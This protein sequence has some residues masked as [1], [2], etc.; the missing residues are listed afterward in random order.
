MHSSSSS[1]IAVAAAWRLRPQARRAKVLAGG[2][3][4]PWLKTLQTPVMPRVSFNLVAT[5]LQRRAGC[6]AALT[7]G[8]WAKSLCPLRQNPCKKPPY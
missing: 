7:G 4:M 2:G 1:S 5:S 3:F 6:A 8:G